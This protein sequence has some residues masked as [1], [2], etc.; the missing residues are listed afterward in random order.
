MPSPGDGLD[1]ESTQ[2]NQRIL[3]SFQALAVLLTV[4]RFGELG[5]KEN[6]DS[7]PGYWCS[8]RSL[9]QINYLL[10]IGHVIPF[11]FSVINNL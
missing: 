2:Q 1:M 8:A 9:Q 3:P 5:P 4:W 11:V 6:T 10:E 7:L